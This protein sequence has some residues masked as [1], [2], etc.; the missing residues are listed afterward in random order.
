MRIVLVEDHHR[1]NPELRAA[2]EACGAEITRVYDVEDALAVLGDG[3]AD[4][5]LAGVADVRRLTRGENQ[6]SSVLRHRINNPLTTIVGQA[7]LLKMALEA[8]S[9]V[10]PDKLAQIEEQALRIRDL[11]AGTKGG[12]DAG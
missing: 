1:E 8:G 4:A 10:D 5:M 7:Q 9:P 2:A 3:A 12:A 11:V 6:I